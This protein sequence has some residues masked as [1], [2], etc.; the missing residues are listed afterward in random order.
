MKC[1]YNDFKEC[2]E[3]DCAAW[4][5]VPD[6]K[7]RGYLIRVCAIAYDGGVPNNAR[8]VDDGIFKESP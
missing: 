5:L 6:P 7:N 2:F 1:P 3:E 4:K 8:R